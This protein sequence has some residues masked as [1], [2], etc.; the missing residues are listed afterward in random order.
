MMKITEL[1]YDVTAYSATMQ[2][3]ARDLSLIVFVHR[4]PIIIYIILN[5]QVLWNR[6]SCRRQEKTSSLVFLTI[7]C[8]NSEQINL[9][10][11]IISD[12]IL[13]IIPISFVLLCKTIIIIHTPPI[14]IVVYPFLAIL[15][16]ILLGLWPHEYS[17][18][19]W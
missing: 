17:Y 7:K 3:S 13:S 15:S 11:C 16:N 14:D 2:S 9:H 4:M 5:F 6:Y 10:G 18:L 19:S 8:Q 1:L 12:V